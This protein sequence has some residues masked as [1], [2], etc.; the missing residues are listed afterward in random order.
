M[1]KNPK[2]RGW[3][4]REIVHCKK[5]RG[6]G[7]DDTRSDFHKGTVSLEKRGKTE[8]WIGVAKRAG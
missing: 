2:G 3:E 1:Q 4:E 7:Q 5:G 8:G 6:G